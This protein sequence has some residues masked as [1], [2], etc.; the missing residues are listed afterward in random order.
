MSENEF[1]SYVTF[2]GIN[3]TTFAYP[4]ELERL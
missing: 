4:C 1:I 2:D 3:G